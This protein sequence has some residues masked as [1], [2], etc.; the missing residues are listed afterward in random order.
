MAQ[1]CLRHN[2]SILEVVPSLAAQYVRDLKP[3]GSQLKIRRFL[4]GGEA[5]SAQLSNS[6]YDVSG[7]RAGPAG[8]GGWSSCCAALHC[9]AECPG[10]RPTLPPDHPPLPSPHHHHRRCPGASACGTPT[11]PPR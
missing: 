7:S 11:A 9:A 8:V 6:V 1:L 2:I 5:L 4:T 10:R 3:L